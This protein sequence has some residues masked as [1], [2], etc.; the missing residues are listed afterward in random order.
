MHQ[1]KVASYLENGNNMNKNYNENPSIYDGLVKKERNDENRLLPEVCSRKSE[2]NKISTE[3]LFDEMESKEE[4]AN[5]NGP[6]ARNYNQNNKINE[7]KNKISED[8]N[9]L[10]SVSKD[11]FFDSLESKKNVD[12]EQEISNSVNNLQPSDSSELKY[13]HKYRPEWEN[14]HDWLQPVTDNLL[15]VKCEAC[16]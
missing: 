9:G 1:D 11:K 16:N 14:L 2:E 3:N 4:G 15:K 10:I 7:L 5:E 13:V 8:E 12:F 6:L